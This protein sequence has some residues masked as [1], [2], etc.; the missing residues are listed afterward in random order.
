VLLWEVL[1]VL[2]TDAGEFYHQ[3]LVF[4][5]V[6]LLAV[7]MYR[8]WRRTRQPALYDLFLAL[9]I[10]VLQRGLLTVAYGLTDI[11]RLVPATALQP[12]LFPIDRALETA[13]LLFLAYAF[14]PAPLGSPRRGRFLAG[15]LAFV[16][17]AYLV[18]QG[19]WLRDLARQPELHFNHHW[20]GVFF[21]GLQLGILA[22]TLVAVALRQGKYRLLAACLLSL[23]WLSNVLELPLAASTAE[24]FQTA[25]ARTFDLA[26]FPI[27]G[28]IVYRNIVDDART[29]RQELQQ[30]NQE[31]D[32]KVAERTRELSI[33]VETGEAL[34]STL[35][36]DS[37]LDIVTARMT[38]AASASGCLLT[39][40]DEDDE[41]VTVRSGFDSASQARS[42]HVGVR[43][44][45]ATLPNVRRLLTG[46]A[47]V[48]EY[49]AGAAVSAE[50][51]AIIDGLG[52]KA[53]LL[54]PLLSRGKS[55]GLVVLYE[56]RAPRRFSPEEVGL[57]K[58]LAHQAAVAIEN[59]RLHASVVESKNELEAIVQ[60][61][62][63]GVFALDRQRRIVIFN[64]ALES[65]TGWQAAEVLGTPCS[66]VLR[67]RDLSHHSL[68]EQNCLCLRAF[69]S[70]QPLTT[71]VLISTKDGREL[72]AG[73]SLGP[74]LD[75][76]G[77]VIGAVGVVRDIT[78]QKE[79]ERM[80]TEF[81]STA[82][83]EL[84]TP[85]TLIKGYLGTLLRPDLRLPPETQT[86]FL[87]QIDEA[88]NRLTGL[89]DDLLSV[90]RLE[91]GQMELRLQPVDLSALVSRVVS[92]FAVQDDGHRLSL[93][94]APLPDHLMVRAD[95]EQIERILL[96]L[97]NNAVKFSPQ[98]GH[99]Q[100]SGC[101]VRV[102]HGQVAE[103]VPGTCPLPAPNLDDGAWVL[104][105]VQDEGI[106]IPPEHQ[107]RIFEKFYQVDSGLTRRARGTG[108]GLYICKGIIEAHGGKIWVESTPGQGSTFVF[109]LPWHLADGR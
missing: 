101:G 55:L 48:I 74:I 54:L 3:F 83:H 39:L 102:E 76:A 86:R 29:A 50:E 107:E 15:A 103:A 12:Y 4:V 19:F 8:E 94:L 47:A 75:Q 69:S 82:S 81:V 18:T 78:R 70:Q 97:L 1:K 26:A 56:S 24:A 20:A 52:A 53:A 40:L 92:T 33:L 104:V 67:A 11:W 71:E 96:N 62:A 42:P 27:F 99:I 49:T 41:H 65:L 105:S 13:A 89:V 44:A 88:A 16:F 77:R 5:A 38:T 63:D 22:F 85:L 73:I 79:V 31:L 90:S 106:G 34:A 17:L 32:R 80:Q 66:L 72:N 36:L 43:R 108:L 21:E 59:A 37:R 109:D 7:G 9:S 60:N 14:L 91:S 100:V 46:E 25:L 84:R 98:G 45:L 51:R 61:S 93:S 10:F 95:A 28:F 2:S 23:L 64:P 30:L 87:R 57:Y 6:T 68:C 35:D 58:A